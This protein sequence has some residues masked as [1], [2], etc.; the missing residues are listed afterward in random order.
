MLIQTAIDSIPQY[1]TCAVMIAALSEFDWIN[2]VSDAGACT[3]G[4]QTEIF[5]AVSCDDDSGMEDRK[6][7]V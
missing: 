2:T 3:E 1:N 5:P 6:S 4:L 7:V